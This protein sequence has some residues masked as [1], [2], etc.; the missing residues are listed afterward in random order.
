MIELCPWCG[1]DLPEDENI[2]C[3]ECG[4]PI[5]THGENL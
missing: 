1:R 2:S 5:C 3:P 4:G